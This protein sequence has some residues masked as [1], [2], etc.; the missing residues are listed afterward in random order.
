MS[1]SSL[2]TLA[3]LAK[4]CRDLGL[5]V[6]QTKAKE[7]KAD[8]IRALQAHF[9]K[10]EFNDNPPKSLRYMLAMDSPMLCAQFKDLREDVWDNLE[11]IAEEKL[12]GVRMV[13]HWEPGQAPDFYSR[14]LSVKDY[15][16]VNYKGNILLDGVDFSKIT[17]SFVLDNEIV[18]TN[19]TVS[20]ILEH[21]AGGVVTE[22]M[23]QAVTALLA[24]EGKD[25][26]EIQRSEAPLKFFAF[27]CLLWNGEDLRDRPYHE[28][29]GY[30][31]KAYAQLKS[32]GVNIALPRIERRNKKE[33]A[34]GIIRGGG[35]GVILKNVLAPYFATNTRSHRVWVKYK[36]TLSQSAKEAGYGDTVDGWISGYELGT[37]GKGNE[38]L[39]SVLHVSV[40]L[41]QDDGQLIEHIIGHVSNL[42][43]ALRENMTEVV[44]GVPRLKAEFYGQVVE[45]EAQDISARVLRGSHCRLIG[46]RPDR[47]SD[48]CI[49]EESFL[50]S[51]VL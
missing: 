14:N 32:A 8:Y 22:T 11:W 35:E 19:P 25:S 17:D 37:E 48:T 42:T 15:L 31:F 40:Y 36:R 27:D 43:A 13:A 47:S 24:M 44:D 41:R 20:T 51:L 46:F 21:R 26:L 29:R 2:R 34:D 38:G 16:P 49:L 18:S 12:D 7:N 4:E 23:L 3:Q 39:V 30:L 45:I 5:T 50:R 9:L 1:V 33:F 6:T 28:R 10:K